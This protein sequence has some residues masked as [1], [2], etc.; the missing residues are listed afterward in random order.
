MLK[1]RTFET[2]LKTQVLFRCMC[3]NLSTQ[4]SQYSDDLSWFLEPIKYVLDRNSISAKLGNHCAT[5]SLCAVESTLSLTNDKPSN[6]RKGSTTYDVMHKDYLHAMEKIYCNDPEMIQVLRTSLTKYVQ[7][8]S[9]CKFP[10]T[11][12]KL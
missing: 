4:K 2:Q 10:K 1:H 12:I 11:T 3:L 9:S 7:K 8:S 5:L 6:K